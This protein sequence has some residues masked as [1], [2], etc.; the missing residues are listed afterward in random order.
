MNTRMNARTLTTTLLASIA[1]IAVL[2]TA[3]PLA[4]EPAASQTPADTSAQTPQ[5]DA[6]IAGPAGET[7]IFLSDDD[8]AACEADKTCLN[9]IA[10]C[11]CVARLFDEIACWSMTC[12]E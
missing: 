12:A 11:Q 3:S 10:Y 7:P 1:L 2:A 9:P 8:V 5:L 4:A 6:V